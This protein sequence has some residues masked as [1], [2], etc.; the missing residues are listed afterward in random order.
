MAM[1]SID[2]KPPSTLEKD[3][4]DLMHRLSAVRD[5]QEIMD[6]V[7]HGARK[8]LGADGVTF[9]LRDGDY[10]YYA[11]EDAI[12]P[13]WK[14]MRFP[15][16][17][18]I[19]GWAMMNHKSAVI[20]DIYQDSRVPQE[21][22]RCTF[23]KSMVMVPVRL[24]DP[25]AAIGAYWRE[26]RQPTAKEVSLLETIANAAAVAMT[27][28][29]LIHSLHGMVDELKQR[30]RE[31]DL[32][33]RAKA[34]FLANMSHE[35]RTPLNIILGF[36][37]AIKRQMHGQLG[38]DKYTTYAAEIQNAGQNLLRMVNDVLDLAALGSGSYALDLEAVYLDDI[39]D[40]ATG[41]VD[42]KLQSSQLTLVNHVDKDLPPIKGDPRLLKQLFFNILSNAVKFSAPGGTITISAETSNKG[43]ACSIAD[44]GIGM[45]QE[46]IE[47]ATR[48]FEQADDRLERRF[49]GAGLGLALCK[50]YVDLHGGDLQIT[51]TPEKGTTITVTL[52]LYE[53]GTDK[54]P[55]A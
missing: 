39:V 3:V 8:L 32:A 20:E 33:Y 45:T 46:E 36:A 28:V 7:R 21:A 53:F 18:C 12:S 10:C 50:G 1:S 17:S 14:G 41:L 47:K 35:L 6:L 22:Y 48:P 44:T 9:V 25:I 23:V 40:T 11:E 27:N 42:Q 34:N 24:E 54:T 30:N 38:N 31:L 52:P 15:L 51:S 37:E 55:R 29:G 49:D 43:V 19:S 13:L 26:E 2:Y 5:A 16:T 4:V